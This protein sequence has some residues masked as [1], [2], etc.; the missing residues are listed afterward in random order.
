M[1]PSGAAAV[2][3]LEAT[4]GRT[5]LTS[6]RF[7]LARVQATDEVGPLI[8]LGPPVSPIL[9]AWQLDV[10]DVG[11]DRVMAVMQSTSL[12]SE[13]VDSTGRVRSRMRMF[14]G[15][16]GSSPQGGGRAAPA[17]WRVAGRARA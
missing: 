3:W 8:D 4:L 6:A 10:A 13:L 15:L 16:G 11:S 12:F 14:S 2:A 9:G 17:A 7:R 5:N 1:R